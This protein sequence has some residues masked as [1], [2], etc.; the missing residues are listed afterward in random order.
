MN[1]NITGI[2]DNMIIVKHDLFARLVTC[3]ADAREHSTIVRQQ[4]TVAG[5]LPRAQVPG[6]TRIRGRHNAVS[7][8]QHSPS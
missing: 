8:W 6:S 1:V 4:V 3:T 2:Y 7:N 5:V